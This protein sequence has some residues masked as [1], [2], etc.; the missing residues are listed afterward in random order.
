MKWNF[1]KFI[2]F[3][4]VIVVDF[5]LVHRYLKHNS[6]STSYTWKHEGKVLDMNKT[7]EGNGV[8]LV[9]IDTGC[10]FSCSG[11][12]IKDES[13]TFHNLSVDGTNEFAISEVQV[14]YNDD[15]TEG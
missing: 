5:L 15:L 9:G 6:H 8:K 7:L 14:Y 10:T 13:E 2:Y 3:F 12:Q 1:G 4:F 11:L